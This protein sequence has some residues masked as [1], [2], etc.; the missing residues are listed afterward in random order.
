[1][2]F[3]AFSTKAVLRKS[4]TMISVVSAI[5]TPASDEGLR[6]RR[7]ILCPLAWSCANSCLPMKPVAPTIRI[8]ASKAG[9]LTVAGIV[10][11]LG[12]ASRASAGNMPIMSSA[13]WAMSMA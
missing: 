12:F 6:T 10:E 3:S 2:P 11:A 13:Q 9:S 4:P 5:S 7:R 8:V 1:M